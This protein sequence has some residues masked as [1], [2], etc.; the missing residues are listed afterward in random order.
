MAL[1]INHYNA[2]FLDSPGQNDAVKYGVSISPC[3][4][5]AGV[6]I[7]RCIGIH[8]LTPT[9]NAGNHHAFLDVLDEQGQRIHQTAIEWSW[10]GRKLDEPAPPVVIDKP[11]TEPGT[12]IP[13][14]WAQTISAS[15]KGHPTDTVINLHTR[16][17][18][19]GE[20]G[21]NSRGHHSFYVVFQ[22]QSG[23][24]PPPPTEPPPP[25]NDL[26]KRI[27]TACD[28]LQQTLDVLQ[29]N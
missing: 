7:Y 16:H 4:R 3:T 6:T 23:D 12:N 27:A 8:H 1:D 13:M 20:N 5:G 17:P 11:D 25:A 29:E 9:E 24:G 26:A 15:V 22:R 28:L 21:G 10:Q 19:E 18:D 14:N 2:L